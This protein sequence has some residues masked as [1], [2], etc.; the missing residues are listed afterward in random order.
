MA[1]AD[2]TTGAAHAAISPG[3]FVFAA[4]GVCLGLSDVWRF[5]YLVLEYDSLW[6]P[7][8]YLA[9]VLL[10][11]MPLLIAELAL[12]RL[13]HSHPSINFGFLVEGT[14]AGA[15]WQYAGILVLITVFLIIS[16]T[17]VVAGWMIAYAVRSILGDFEGVSA[18]VTRL[19]FHSLISDPERLLGWHT[20]FVLALGWVAGRGA[21]AG[22]GRFSRRL[23]IGV[24]AIA[25]PLAALSVYKFGAGPLLALDW[26]AH[27]SKLTVPLVLDAMTQA[28]FTLGVC[29][30]AMMIL[31]THLSPGARLGP[32]VLGVVGLDTVFVVLACAAVVP[33]LGAG[34]AAE[35]GIS[36]AVETVPLALA[37]VPMGRIYLAA[38]YVVLFLLVAT[39][40]LVLMEFLVSWI[41]EKTGRSRTAAAVAAAVAVWAG[42]LL[43]LLSFSSFSFEFEFVGKAK[44][45]GLFDV[46]DILSARILLPLIGILMTVFVGWKIDRAT[47]TA[48]TGWGRAGSAL[49]ILKRYLVPVAV[50][51]V[52]AGLVFGRVLYRV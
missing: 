4:A 10:V 19:V 31:G 29:M 35:E 14:G 23:V 38:F 52:F 27:W 8:V 6:F 15:L 34:K 3:L 22:A 42:G 1:A 28:F 20:L 16:Y 18:G 11:G 24:F 9:G 50:G 36:F 5:P 47:F 46:M 12:A 2:S 40:A 51:L 43:A 48:A 26:T 21:E 44:H 37:A 17:T 32:I 30:G 39:T 49:H 33:V 13:G 7:L 45:F 41:V 25:A